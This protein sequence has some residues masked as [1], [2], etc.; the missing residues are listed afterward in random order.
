MNR[1]SKIGLVALMGIIYAINVCKAQAFTNQHNVTI[2][3]KKPG[4]PAVEYDLQAKATGENQ[5][6]YFVSENEIPVRIVGKTIDNDNKQL[7]VITIEALDNIYFNY[8]H[9]IS[10]SF[11]HEQCQFLMPGFWYRRNYRSPKEAPSFHTSDSWTVREDRLSAPLTGIFN[12]KTGGYYTITRIDDFS[13][14]ALTT[15]KSGEVIVSGKT[16]IGFTGF[17]NIDGKATLAF[18][19][20]YNESPET[21]IRKL[22]LLPEVKAFQFLP[23]GEKIQL[24]WEVNRENAA[25]FSQFVEQVWRYSYNIYK[26]KIIDVYH[27]PEIMKN[28][29][30]NF[31]VESFVSEHKLKYMSG[32]HMYTESCKNTGIAEVGFV[33]RT[34][35][36]AFNAFEYGEQHNRKD[37]VENSTEIFDSYL[38]QGFTDNGFFCEL[39]NFDNNT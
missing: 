8:S 31:F 5:L 23:K 26:P 27:T 2:S 3:L 25:D 16:S 35:L 12:E 11:P 22:T 18:G 14:E 37:L 39:R 1:F 20:P 13:N 28:E 7:I 32:V 30:S 17:K 38:K 19:F 4:N 6:N 33:G 21:Y 34:L 29:I 24:E 10:T 15:H 36:N 9:Q